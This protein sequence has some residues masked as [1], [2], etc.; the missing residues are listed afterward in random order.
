MHIKQL[1]RFHNWHGS[2]VYVLLLMNKVNFLP[3]SCYSAVVWIQYENNVDST[4]VAK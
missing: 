1:Y 4:V 2:R 3:S